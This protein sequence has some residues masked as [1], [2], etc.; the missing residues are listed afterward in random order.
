MRLA[1]RVRYG[2]EVIELAPGDVLERDGYRIAAV[3]VAHRVE[4]FGYVIY[5]DER[6]GEFDTDAA[7]RLGLT[8][9]TRVRP[10]A[11]RRDRQGG[12]ARAGARAARGP[13]ARS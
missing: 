7:V 1:G 6:P 2:L 12:L 8:P 9:G 10:G 11:A 5:E 13:G 4:A 3:P